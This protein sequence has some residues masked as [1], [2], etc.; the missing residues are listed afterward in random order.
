MVSDLARWPFEDE[1]AVR[2]TRDLL[3][4]LAVIQIGQS[5]D[6]PLSE[7]RDTFA[8]LPD[9]RTPTC[10][11]GGP[12]LL[13]DPARS[14]DRRSHSRGDVTDIACQ[15]KAMPTTAGRPGMPFSPCESTPSDYLTTDV[16]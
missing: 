16:K 1:A 14:Q 5:V 15:G 8:G 2:C 11:L 3:R 12:R 4:R 10:G 6:I 13:L 7:L 9:E